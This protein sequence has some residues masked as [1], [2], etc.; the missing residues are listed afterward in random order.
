MIRKNYLSPLLIGA[1]LSVSL[2]GCSLEEDI[3]RLKKDVNIIKNEA[4]QGDVSLK[5]T[6]PEGETSV[7][8]YPGETK[9]VSVSAEGISDILVDGS[10]PQGWS[11]SYDDEKKLLTITAPMAGIEPARISVSGTNDKGLVYRAILN[12]DAAPFDVKGGVYVLNEGNMGSENGSLVFVSPNHHAVGAVYQLINGTT[13]GNVTEDL[14]RFGDKL[15]VIAQNRKAGT[16]GRLTVF[17]G[18]TLKKV[19]NYDEEL[20]ELS[21]PSHLAILDEANIFIRD[22]KG[23]YRFDS[24]SKA[25]S[26]VNGSDGARKNT[27]IISG[28]KAFATAGKE[29][30]VLEKGASE[31]SAAIEFPAAISGLSKAKEGTIYV[32][33]VDGDKGYIAEVSD[34]DYS[35]LKTNEVEG[36]SVS[37]MSWV[38]EASSLISAKGDTVYYS[39]TRPVIYR[40]IF[41]TGETKKMFDA[42]TV[43]PDHTVTYNTVTVSPLTGLVYLNTITGWGTY[44][45]NTFYEIDA[46]GAEGKLVNRYDDFTRFPAGIFFPFAD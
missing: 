42:L 23:I 3:S 32:S 5:L 26:F 8:F 21:M 45:V 34:K 10:A 25:L 4:K 36:E 14:A 29:L 12:C 19:T 38:F 43:N 6:L 20:A 7:L 30:L 9:T 27:M 18:K 22:N 1:L 24:G 33:Y 17:D 41:S 46:K 44:K 28:G 2:I 39:A 31:V 37:A 16:D 15:Y 13:F 40:H 35:I 11:G